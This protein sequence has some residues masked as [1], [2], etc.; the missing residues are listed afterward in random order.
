MPGVGIERVQP[1]SGSEK[2]AGIVALAPV[3]Y[4]A[5]ERAAVIGQG[6]FPAQFTGMGIQREGLDRCGYAIKDSVDD[7]GVALNLTAVLQRVC[8]L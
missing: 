8:I 3:R 2:D 1:L 4:P 6:R 5:A 7:N